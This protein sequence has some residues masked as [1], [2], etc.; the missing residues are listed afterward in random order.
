MAKY[1]SEWD[2]NYVNPFQLYDSTAQDCTVCTQYTHQI[3][4]TKIHYRGSYVWICGGVRFLML[5]VIIINVIHH[6]LVSIRLSLHA[7]ECSFHFNHGSKCIQ[8]HFQIRNNQFHKLWMQ[9][10]YQW[11]GQI[12]CSVL[13]F[14]IL[15]AFPLCDRKLN[16]FK[17]FFKSIWHAKFSANILPHRYF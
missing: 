11:V 3:Q 5:F 7:D 14:I 16:D 4:S 2:L 9:W 12:N 10:I 1:M 6:I 15:Y 8:N 17:I 13:F